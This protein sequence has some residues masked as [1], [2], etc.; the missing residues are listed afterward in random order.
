[1][2]KIYIF[3]Y[4]SYE[5]TVQTYVRLI[6]SR[7]SLGKAENFLAYYKNSWNR[8]GEKDKNEKKK[9]KKSAIHFYIEKV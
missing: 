9:R 4:I 3:K 1:M 5:Y 6:Y 8:E 7:Q 2:K